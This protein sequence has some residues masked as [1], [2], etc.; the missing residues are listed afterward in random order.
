M[1]QQLCGAFPANTVE[2]KPRLGHILENK[3]PAMRELPLYTWGL[4][5][6]TSQH[7]LGP[8]VV[9]QGTRGE[10]GMP[11]NLAQRGPLLYQLNSVIC[12]RILFKTHLWEGTDGGHLLSF[13]KDFSSPEGTSSLHLQLS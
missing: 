8:S 13:L 7:F 1:S 12:F 2:S 9:S 5:L 3:E 11:S 4:K 10:N 6:A